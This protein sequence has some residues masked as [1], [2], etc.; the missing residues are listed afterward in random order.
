MFSKVLK[1]LFV[2]CF[3]FAISANAERKTN[4]VTDNNRRVQNAIGCGPGYEIFKNSK[5]HIT[6]STGAST[7]MS[8]TGSTARTSGTSGCDN[9]TLMTFNNAKLVN[10]YIATNMSQFMIDA[11]YGKGETLD[12]VASLMSPDDV[13]TFEAKVHADYDKIFTSKDVTSQEVT[14]NL[15]RSL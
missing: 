2:I 7:N 5:S 8:S 9:R 12:I 11:S 13:K 6:L 3:L 4:K 14:N 1:T 10:D 15:Y